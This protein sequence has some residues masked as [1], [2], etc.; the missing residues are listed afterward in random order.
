M[1]TPH[2]AWYLSNGNHITLLWIVENKE[3]ESKLQQCK[4]IVTD[5]QS[6]NL[7]V[8]FTNKCRWK[9]TD[10]AGRYGNN[11]NLKDEMGVINMISE[12]LKEAGVEEV[13]GMVNGAIFNNWWHSCDY[14][15]CG[16]EI[17]QSPLTLNVRELKWIDK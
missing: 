5:L 6:Q 4:K 2:I 17:F 3:N 8:T 16:D 14:Q 12:R 7:S 15:G 1:V 10:K 11:L 13:Q 9:K